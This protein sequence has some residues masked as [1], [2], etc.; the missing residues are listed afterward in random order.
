MIGE[1][2]IH[3]EW[4]N[5]GIFVDINMFDSLKLIIDIYYD[6]QHSF[7]QYLHDYFVN[8]DIFGLKWRSNTII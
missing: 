4:V 6:G 1:I 3:K 8:Y 2:L 7:K 5:D